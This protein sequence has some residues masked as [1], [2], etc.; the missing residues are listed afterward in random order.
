MTPAERI[1]IIEERLR[2]TFSP[3][4]LEIVDDSWRHKGHEGSRDGAGHYTVIIATA[5]FANKSRIDAHREIYA[6]LDD[7]I[8][9]EV[10]ALQIKIV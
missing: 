5:H 7:L 8:P 1:A 3:S 6:V 2:T 4:R 10:H 9:Q